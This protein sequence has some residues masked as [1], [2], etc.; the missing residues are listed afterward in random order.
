MNAT[1]TQID[2]L[3]R[4]KSPSYAEQNNLIPEHDKFNFREIFL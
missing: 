1:I 2:L 4:D 3:S